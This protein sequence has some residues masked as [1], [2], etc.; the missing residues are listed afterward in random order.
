MTRLTKYSRK[1]IASA[2]TAHSFDPKSELLA[3]TE[4][5]LA[6]EAYDSVI[7]AAEKK[8]AEAMPSNWYR[9]DACLRFNVGGYSLHLNLIGDGLPVPYKAKGE[10]YGGYH[11]G[12]LG[13]IP[14]GDLCDRIQAHAQAKDSL[15]TE[16][17]KAYRAVIT[18]LDG[19]STVKRLSEVWPEGEQFCAKYGTTTSAN[20]P[21]VRV[22]EVNAMLGIGAA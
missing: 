7:P 14:A 18:M 22:D 21:A 6:Q 5:A 1:A 4:D 9:R 8:A 20:L 2:A 11:F 15:R 13:S 16:R 10:E 3:A 12:S 19:V 17:Q